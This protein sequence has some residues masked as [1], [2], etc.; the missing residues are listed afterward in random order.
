MSIVD[1]CL[2]E[3]LSRAPV[4][5]L[6]RG[7]SPNLALDQRLSRR[8]AAGERVVHLGLGESRLPVHPAL[9]DRLA[10][11]AEAH[12]YGPVA[13][14]ESVLRAGAGYFGRRRLPT[15]PD[16]IVIAPGSKAALFALI[17]ALPGDVVLPQPCWVSYAAQTLF[18][19]RRVIGVP[20]PA[21]CGGVPDPSLLR[22]RITEARRR[23]EDPR[24]VILTVP[25]NPTGTTAAPET[26][27]RVC[28]VAE[29]EGLVVLSDEIYRDIR[30]DPAVPYLSAAEV[31][32]ARTVVVTGLSK[33]L[34][35]GGW[36]IGVARFPPGAWGHDLRAKVLAVGSEV[37]S[38]VAAPM[39]EVAAYAFSEPPEIV[40]HLEASA[41]LHGTVAA[42]V[43]RAVVAAG[44]RCNPPQGGFYVYPDFEPVRAV[45]AAKGIVDAAGLQSYLLDRWGIG[46]LGGH[47]FGDEP[48]GLRFRAATSQLYGLTADEQWAS[49]RSAD[50]TGLPHVAGQ[51]A[52]LREA[53]TALTRGAE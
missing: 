19:G 16:Q 30:H 40:E 24:I 23:G 1:I 10:T 37:W 27:R 5:V 18:A 13:G 35:L 38:T 51:L 26:V 6:P 14:G 25:D 45:L 41:R 17:A 43:H 22:E 31:L 28:A 8:I 44:A 53:F 33:N 12:S 46:V 48:G 3:S 39:Q 2:R 21:D 49:L 7:V 36:R 47:H 11:A 15:A 34:A 32:P 42:A 9:V 52:R 20:V 4:M 50:P 29:A